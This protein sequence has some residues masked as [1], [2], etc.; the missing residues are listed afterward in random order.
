MGSLLHAFGLVGFSI[1][2]TLFIIVL[3]IINPFLAIGIVLVGLF[4]VAY[5]CD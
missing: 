1:S 4:L 3:S 5:F 2:A